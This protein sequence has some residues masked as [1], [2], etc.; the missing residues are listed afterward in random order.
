WRDFLFG[1]FKGAPV[2]TSYVDLWNIGNSGINFN[3]N[4]QW[5][6]NRRRIDV[7]LKIPIP[8][9]A[10]FHLDLGSGWRAERWDVSS[11]LVP[12]LR[13]KGLLD[14]K[15]T[16]LR[17]HVKQ[18]PHYR[19]ELGAGFEYRNRAAKGNRAAA[20]PSKI[21]SFCVSTLIR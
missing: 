13:S 10:F 5:D 12:E 19:V 8:W 20:C 1:V 11:N 15:A 17:V 16:A 14:Y 6:T 21:A 4:Y 7:R 9:P 2:Q 3:G 18:I